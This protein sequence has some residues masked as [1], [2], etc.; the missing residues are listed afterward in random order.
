MKIYELNL[1]SIEHEEDEDDFI[2]E[3]LS[4]A[5][6]RQFFDDNEELILMCKKFFKNNN[7]KEKIYIKYKNEY[8]FLK[9]ET[10]IEDICKNCDFFAKHCKN[11][12]TCLTNMLFGE[13]VD[14]NLEKIPLYEI[15]FS[16]ENT[17]I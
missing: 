5:Q 6:R 8:Y 2:E 4:Y 11:I 12:S 10:D 17:E 7:N 15:V 14:I 9:K 16:N 1:N 3:Y 13:H